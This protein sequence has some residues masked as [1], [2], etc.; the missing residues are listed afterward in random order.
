MVEAQHGLCAVCGE[1]PNGENTRAH[2]GGKLCV[3]HDHDTEK[4]RGLLCNDCNLAVGYGK[5]PEKL[6]AA[7]EYLQRHA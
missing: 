6:R 7:A 3:D 4:I 1:P 5:T 2:W